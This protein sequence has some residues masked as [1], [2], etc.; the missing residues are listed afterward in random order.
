[1]VEVER[2]VHFTRL[3]H[4]LSSQYDVTNQ[5]NHAIK[6]S[7]DQPSFLFTKFVNNNSFRKMFQI[8]LNKCPAVIGCGASVSCSEPNWAQ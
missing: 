4:I 6:V 3:D 5:G 1:M 7:L 8:Y 2:K